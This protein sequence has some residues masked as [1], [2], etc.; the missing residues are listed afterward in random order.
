MI[1]TLLP[2]TL[3][4]TLAASEPETH[5]T[6]D[7]VLALHAGEPDETLRYGDAP[8]QFAELWLPPGE[9][10]PPL[11]VLI[12]GG[13]WLNRFDV[14]HTRP[15]ASRIRDEGYAVYSLEYRR[16]GD[17][18]GGWPGTFEDIANGVDS[19]R[20][21]AGRVDLEHSVIMGHSAGGH[22]A[23]W[24]GRRQAFGPE[25]PFR[26]NAPFEPAAVI[27]LAAIVDLHTYSLGGSS[28]EQAT[29]SLLGG[30][31]E[32]VEARYRFTSPALLAAGARTILVQ[33]TADRIVP[34]EQ[35]ASLSD[36]GPGDILEVPGAGHFDLIFPAGPTFDVV[37]AALRLALP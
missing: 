20:K 25:N 23:V 16:I 7:D 14:G 35:A 13:C 26:E 31:F 33:G 9:T 28:C 34:L 27:G 8:E 19:V 32:E 24:A 6:F 18:G 12:H 3:M 36:V 37:L 15:M 11:V 30:A 2:I 22:L 17:S 21:L 29:V 4:L 5:V 10:A 1:H